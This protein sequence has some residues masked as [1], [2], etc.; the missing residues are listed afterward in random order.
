MQPYTLQSL[1]ILAEAGSSCLPVVASDSQVPTPQS[2]KDSQPLIDAQ[3]ANLGLA[4]NRLYGSHNLVHLIRSIF[5]EI[6]IIFSPADYSFTDGVLRTKAKEVVDRLFLSRRQQLSNLSSESVGRV[7]SAH[8]A[9]LRSTTS[10]MGPS[11]SL[12]TTQLA[13][14]FERE[15][16]Q[17]MA[18]LQRRISELQDEN[19]ELRAGA[20]LRDPSL[21]PSGEVQDQV[22]GSSFA[23]AASHPSE[24]EVSV[25][26][27]RN[28]E[29]GSG[30][31]P[32]VL[33]RA[34]VI[35]NL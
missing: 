7:L 5:T 4:T 35:L 2:L 29:H 23:S 31:A 20:A 30:H 26:A 32:I 24:D 8:P 22:W 34:Q 28:S 21:V 1:P 3:I 15:I 12:L 6:A 19:G 14:E 10:T 17:E 11:S 16:Q 25:R 9:S 13:P 18:V 27:L 33:R